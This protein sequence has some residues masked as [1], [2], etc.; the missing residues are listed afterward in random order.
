MWNYACLN[1]GLRLMFNGQKFESKR[2]LLD[3]L[4]SEGGRKCDLRSGPLQIP[5]P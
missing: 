2:G 3:L 5:L 1:S 4:Q